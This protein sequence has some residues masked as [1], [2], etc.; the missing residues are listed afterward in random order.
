MTGFALKRV[1]VKG[2]GEF[3]VHMRSFNFRYLDIS[4]KLPRGFEEIEPV[5]YEKISRSIMRGRIDV[6]MDFT[7][8]SEKGQGFNERSLRQ[9]YASAQALKKTFNLGGEVDLRTL[10]SLADKTG[11]IRSEVSRNV[12]VKAESVFDRALADLIRFKRKQGDSIKRDLIRIINSL[13]RGNREF[14]EFIKKSLKQEELSKDVFE[15]FSLI[16]FYL[17]HLKGMLNEKRDSVGKLLDFLSQELLRE[18][19]TLLAKIKNKQV[20]LRAV[21]FKE[22]IDRIREISNNIE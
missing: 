6:Y 4:I 1:Y 17:D 13:H 21:Y 12:L 8:V 2:V 10:F 18:V 11:T 3:K 22:E 5:I 20:S 9:A 16:T 19:N 7:S 15:E 14:E